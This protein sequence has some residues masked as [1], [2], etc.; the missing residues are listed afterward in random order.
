M[1]Q[2]VLSDYMPQLVWLAITFGALYLFLERAIIPR[3]ARVLAQREE[4]LRKDA[5]GIE[6]INAQASTLRK[7]Q[8]KLLTQA[9]AQAQATVQEGIEKLSLWRHQ[10]E[11]KLRATLQAE[12]TKAETRI[13]SAKSRALEE[14]MGEGAQAVLPLA[15]SIV[16]KISGEVP[17]KDALAEAARR[18]F[19]ENVSSSQ[20]A[21]DKH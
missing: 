16:S 13:L 9:Q 15:S 21:P 11:H 18:A 1:P 7:E 20:R 5:Q 12:M 17:P 2:L 3:I 14:L 19:A 6:R 8:E 4:Q 10:Q